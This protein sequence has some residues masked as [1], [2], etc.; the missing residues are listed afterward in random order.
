[1]TVIALCP[2][3][4]EESA[5]VNFIAVTQSGV[6]L[7]FSTIQISLC[8]QQ[9][10]N[11]NLTEQQLKPQ[12]LYLLHVRLP[13]GYTPNTNVGKPK[14]VHSA[15]Y[16][17]GSLLMVSTPQQDHDLLWS[18]SS[19]PF[20]LRTFLTESS[21]L[22]PVD[23]Q[24]WAIAEVKEKT[25]LSIKYPLKEAQTPK[26]VVLLTSQGAHIVELLKPIDLLQQVLFASH[27]TQNDAVKVFFEIQ[28]E[29]HSCANSLLLACMESL[30][31]TEISMWAKNAFYRFGG[32]AFFVQSQ[33]NRTI[34]ES[35]V[36]I[37]SWILANFLYLLL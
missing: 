36:R 22:M 29:P 28:S 14:Q 1:M 37:H 25:S 34:G 16:N 3:S 19:E 32:E 18:L 11:N 35:S 8:Y 26:K 30:R 15:Y 20:P 33:A 9:Q 13:P 12:H 21:T 2:I 24:V 17:S 27:G 4:K 10:Q 23:G 31:G 5:Q 7:Y 6:R